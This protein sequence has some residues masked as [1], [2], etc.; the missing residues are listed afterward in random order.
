MHNYA[1]LEANRRRLDVVASKLSEKSSWHAT[2]QRAASIARETDEVR[3]GSIKSWITEGAE[4]DT[5]QVTIKLNGAEDP[6][7]SSSWAPGSRIVDNVAGTYY[8]LNGSRREFAG[9]ITITATPGLYVGITKD[10]GDYMT[11]II[12]RTAE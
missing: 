12:Y 8:T 5:L 3:R 1:T 6:T 7:V 11:L 9:V 10:G 2:A 4:L